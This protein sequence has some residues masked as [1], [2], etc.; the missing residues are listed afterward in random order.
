MI[1][2]GSFKAKAAEPGEAYTDVLGLDQLAVG[3]QQVVRIGLQRVLLC[4]TDEHTVHAVSDVCP[5]ALQ[6]LIGGKVSDGQVR[7]AK[8]GACFDLSD[9]KSLNAVTSKT[10]PVFAL[11][12]REGRIEVAL[13]SPQTGEST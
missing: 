2:L 10:L 7:C 1:P 13:R 4:R 6:P 5:H 9:G 12:L 3:A 11:R 8:H